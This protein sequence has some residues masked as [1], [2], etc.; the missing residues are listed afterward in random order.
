MEEHPEYKLEYVA[1][2]SGFSSMATFRRAFARKTGEVP[3]QFA[4]KTGGM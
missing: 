2:Q 3:S 1:A 4:E